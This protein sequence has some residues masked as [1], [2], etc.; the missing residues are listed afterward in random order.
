MTTGVGAGEARAAKPLNND[1]ASAVSAGVRPLQSRAMSV[2][3]TVDA[4]IPAKTQSRNTK[5]LGQRLGA[6]GISAAAAGV[7][8]APVITIIDRAIIENASGRNSLGTSMRKSMK[9]LLLRPHNFLFSKPFGLIFTLYFGTYLA[10]NTLDTTSSTLNSKPASTT[11]S[12]P[13]KFIA[14]STTN[15]S[16]CL[17]KDSRFTKLFGV[18]APRAIPPAS[19]ALFAARD[20]L[21]IFASFNVPPV[22]APHLPMNAAVER[23]MS[24]ASAAQFLAPAAVQAFSTPLHLLGLDLY[25]RNGGTPFLDRLKKVRT[26]WFKST[27]ARMGRIVPAFGVGGVVNNTVRSRMMKTLE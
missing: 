17:Y 18:A 4:I 5:R 10:A 1:I 3:S 21:T 20:C 19:Y 24:R 26:D 7:L 22:I 11:T 14:T 23:Y 6:D 25:N 16:L 15:L 2:G 9:T 27:L 8:V 12:G 13:T